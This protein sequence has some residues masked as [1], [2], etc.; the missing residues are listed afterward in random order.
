MR[1]SSLL[2]ERGVTREQ[3]LRPTASLVPARMGRARG[4]QGTKIKAP[5]TRL[6]HKTPTVDPIGVQTPKAVP[7]S[8]S[9][10]QRSCAGSEYSEPSALAVVTG[11]LQQCE[12]NGQDLAGPGS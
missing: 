10:S 1:A 4:I 8:R 9:G 12:I 2:M 7:K 3:F 6:A 11:R 5:D